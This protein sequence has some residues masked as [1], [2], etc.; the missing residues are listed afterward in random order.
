MSRSLTPAALLILS[1][2]SRLPAPAAC[3]AGAA[4]LTFQL[5]VE[6]GPATPARPIRAVNTLLPGQTVIFA[7]IGAGPE[8]LSKGKVSIVLVPSRSGENITIVKPQPAHYPSRWEVP[9][10]TRVVALV[11]GPGG[12]DIGKVSSLVSRDRELVEQLANYAEQTSRTEELLQALAEWDRTPTGTDKLNAALAGFST[13]FGRNIPHLN[14][15]AP[16]DEQLAT[17]LRAINPALSAYDPLTPEPRQRMAQSAM[18]ASSVA[19]LFFGGPVGLAAGGAAMFV[20]L[21]DMVFPDTE[22]RSAFVQETQPYTL[23]L[24]AKRQPHRSRT[25]LAYLWAVR[26]PDIDT[27]ALALEPPVHLLAGAAT[28]VKVRLK[29]P[30]AARFLHRAHDWRLL[31]ASGSNPVPVGVRVLPDAQALEIDLRQARPAPAAYRLA[32]KWDWTE[33][34]AEGEVVVHELRGEPVVAPASRDRLVRGSGA[35]PVQLAGCDFQFVEKLELRKPDGATDTLKF[36]L[37]LGPRAGPQ[38]ELRTLI[39]TNRLEPGHYTLVLTMT[40]GATREAALRILPPHPK[41][42]PLPLRVNLGESVQRIPVTGEGLDR[43]TEIECDHADVELVGDKLVVRLGPAARKGDRLD[44]RLKIE[45]VQAPVTISS[46]LEVTGPRPRFDHIQVSLPGAIGIELANGE[47]PA[48]SFATFSLRIE[49]PSTAP[50]LHLACAESEM[51]LLRVSVR[52]GQER[53]AVRLRWTG[54]GALFLSLDPGAIG[55]SG[56]TLTAVAETE[57]EGRSDPRPLGKVVRLPWIESFEL[58]DEPAGDGAYF[59][60]LQGEDLEVIER[61]GWNAWFGL[62]VPGLPV[63]VAGAGHKQRLRIALP[64][65]SPTPHAPLYIWLRGE[66]KGRATTARY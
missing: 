66:Q 3:P 50:T 49:P 45:G 6:S 57:T 15:S 20:N 29:D 9:S 14:R 61:A 23:T 2:F 55:Q 8:K 28:P 42:A 12:L 35:V 56:C 38:Q 34:V 62:E 13:A 31:P 36:D 27:P 4:L 19:G 18:L 46:A 7:P 40:G 59:G 37:P 43:I 26:V 30:S 1:L 10:R 64:W 44:L 5:A 11:Y 16:A 60:I 48:G 63:P 32:T 51:T 52:P 39:D 17:L 58:S 33:V 41:I 47:L 65:P 21:S 24:C 25:R 53:E 54:P 22:F